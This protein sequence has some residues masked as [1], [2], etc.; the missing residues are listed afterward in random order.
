M[1]CFFH[2]SPGD[3]DAAGFGTTLLTASVLQSRASVAKGPLLAAGYIS[4]TAGRQAG[5]ARE[6][7]A[8][9]VEGAPG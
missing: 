9:S 7:A 1:I 2:K 8:L 4:R 6:A 5:R 3:A